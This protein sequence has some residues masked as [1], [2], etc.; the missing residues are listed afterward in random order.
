ME[1]NPGHSQQNVVFNTQLLHM[2]PVDETGSVF[3]QIIL[4]QILSYKYS[5]KLTVHVPSPQK[6]KQQ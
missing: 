4:S 5:L 3:F 2:C 6:Q 1:L